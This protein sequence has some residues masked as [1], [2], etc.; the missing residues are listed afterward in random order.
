MPLSARTKVADFTTFD[1]P[2]RWASAQKMQEQAVA[3]ASSTS[4][5]CILRRGHIDL[6]PNLNPNPNPNPNL[7][8]YPNLEP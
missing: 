4:V 7:E 8:P 6:D 1:R 5:R 3:T 2:T